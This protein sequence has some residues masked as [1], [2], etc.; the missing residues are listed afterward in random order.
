MNVT[1]TLSLASRRR[2]RPRISTPSSTD[3]FGAVPL[4]GAANAF[5]AS[6]LTGSG[7]SSA[8]RISGVIRFFVA[9]AAAAAADFSAAALA[10][11]GVT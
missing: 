2:S 7:L 8:L 4:K 11:F 10:G 6:P 3:A 9:S 5:I 1:A